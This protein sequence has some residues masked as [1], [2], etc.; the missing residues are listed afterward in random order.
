MTSRRIAGS[1]R[2]ATMRNWTSVSITPALGLSIV[3][4]D[5]TTGE[6]LVIPGGYVRR[7]DASEADVS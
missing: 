4:R 2:L 5:R 3:I 1:L 6:P 7:V